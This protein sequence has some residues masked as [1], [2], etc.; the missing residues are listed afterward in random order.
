MY[1]EIKSPK[2]KKQ[3]PVLILYYM[4]RNNTVFSMW[5]L[6]LF[7][8]YSCDIAAI[9]LQTTVQYSILI[10]IYIFS[11]ICVRTF[12]AL[13][14][15]QMQALCGIWTVYYQLTDATGDDCSE[16]FVDVYLRLDSQRH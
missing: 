4:E 6:F 8:L 15:A 13:Q 12:T 5:Y 10:L 7:A 9:Q 14:L 1:Y 16:D 2:R 11:M 3:L